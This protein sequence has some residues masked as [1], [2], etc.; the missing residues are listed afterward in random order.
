M[1]PGGDW[2][3]PPGLTP[4]P[5]RAFHPG[6]RRDPDTLRHPGNPVRRLH[7]PLMPHG[8]GQAWA[9]PTT[10]RTGY[11]TVRPGDRVGER[12]RGHLEDGGASGRAVA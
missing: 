8:V 1:A 2:T 3:L 9:T 5:P 10:R 4:A 6:G 12:V 11:C 7:H